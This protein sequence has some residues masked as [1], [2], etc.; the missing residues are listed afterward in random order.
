MQYGKSGYGVTIFTNASGS[1]VKAIFRGFAEPANNG[2][3]TLMGKMADRWLPN[4]TQEFRQ[5]MESTGDG[6]T[7]WNS[8]EIKTTDYRRSKM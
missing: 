2:A 7:K 5:R 4:I 1:K 6:M 8:R 3:Y